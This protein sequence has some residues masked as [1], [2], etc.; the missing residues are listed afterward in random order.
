MKKL[1]LIGLIIVMMFSMGCSR[2][3]FNNNQDD[4]IQGDSIDVE[5]KSLPSDNIEHPFE[6]MEIDELYSYCKVSPDDCETFCNR[7]NPEHEI[8]SMDY[9]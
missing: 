5:S 3:E 2:Q 9:K 6:L 4:I 8:C 1:I 7:I